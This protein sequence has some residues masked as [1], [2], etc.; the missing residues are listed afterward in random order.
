MTPKRC[1]LVSPYLKWTHTL[2]YNLILVLVLVELYLLMSLC[3]LI[4]QHL[5]HF[6]KFLVLLHLNARVI[7]YLLNEFLQ[8]LELSHL[9]R[10]DRTRTPTHTLHYHFII[11]SHLV[12]ESLSAHLTADGEH[13]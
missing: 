6:I 12:T 13:D 4:Q 1:L 10:V 7:D 11:I 8:V 9:R 5:Q 3:V 2:R